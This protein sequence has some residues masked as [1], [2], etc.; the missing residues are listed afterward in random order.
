MDCHR[1]MGIPVKGWY[2]VKFSWG[3][4]HG[5]YLACSWKRVEMVSF[6]DKSVEGMKGRKG[7][8]DVCLV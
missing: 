1:G 7:E 8:R 4:R 3:R 5:D 6:L 2:H